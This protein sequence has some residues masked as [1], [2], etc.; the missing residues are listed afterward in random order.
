TKIA[1]IH[2]EGQPLGYPAVIIDTPG[3]NDPF[4]VRD[5]ITHASLGDADIYLVVLTAQQPLSKSDLALLRML[6][7]LQKDRIIAVVNRTDILTAAAGD[8]QRLT[9]F[10]ENALRQEFPHAR[11]P[12]ILASARWANAALAGDD[13]EMAGLL[14]P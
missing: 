1:E 2:L 12:V 10:V 7:G 6:R 3:V 13:K 8:Y 5:E 14:G 4:L 11:I 9:A